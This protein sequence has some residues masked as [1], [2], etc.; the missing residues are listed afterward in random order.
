MAITKEEARPGTHV[1]I[2]GRVD[3]STSAGEHG[4]RTVICWVANPLSQRRGDK[5]VSVVCDPEDVIAE[6]SYGAYIGDDDDAEAMENPLEGKA[7]AL[8]LLAKLV[9][10]AMSEGTN[11][12]EL[13][14]SLDTGVGATP[15]LW[16]TEPNHDDG[17]TGNIVAGEIELTE[18][19]AEL[20]TEVQVAIQQ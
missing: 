2:R 9:D 11:T 13:R 16:V 5:D 12:V 8:S 4:T 3:R 1:L 7:P 18:A 19:E 14:F 20:L 17:Q 6:G 10:A 15:Q